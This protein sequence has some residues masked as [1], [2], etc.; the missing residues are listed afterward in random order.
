MSEPSQ[1]C[2]E[3]VHEI[4]AHHYYV[5]MIRLDVLAWENGIFI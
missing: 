1:P 2:I 4:I 3:F 5:I